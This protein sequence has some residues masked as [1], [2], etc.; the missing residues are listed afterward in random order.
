MSFH[1]QLFHLYLKTLAVA[2]TVYP[3]M[4]AIF[5]NSKME[6]AQKEAVLAYIGVISWQIPCDKC[7]N[8]LVRIISTATVIRE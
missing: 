3:L 8:R 1:Q 4:A 6:M 2:R 5:V 7:R